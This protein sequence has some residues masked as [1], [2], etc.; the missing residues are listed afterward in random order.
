MNLVSGIFCID[1][2]TRFDTNEF[3]VKN[4]HAEDEFPDWRF[5]RLFIPIDGSEAHRDKCTLVRKTR[6]NAVIM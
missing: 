2:D 1:E 4:V 3:W 5:R 6:R